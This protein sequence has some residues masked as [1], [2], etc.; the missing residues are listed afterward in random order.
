M[1]VIVAGVMTAMHSRRFCF[2]R[3]LGLEP[4]GGGE[5]GCLVRL[6]R[7][8]AGEHVDE[9]LADIDAKAAAVFHDGV[10]DR[11]GLAGLLTA[12]EQPVLGTNLG[13][14]HGVFQQVVVDL[15]PPVGQEPAEALPVA[16]DIG[17]R[18]AQLAL[19]Q[20]RGPQCE[21]PEDFAEPLENHPGFRRA[22]RGPQRGAGLGLAQA[23]FDLVEQGVLPQ[24]PAHQPGILRG[25]LGELAPGVGVAAGQPDPRPLGRPGAVGAVGVALDEVQDVVDLF[26]GGL[27]GQFGVGAEEFRRAAGITPGTPLVEH[28]A[29]GN[30]AHPEV[31][32]LGL[33]GAGFEISDGGFVKLSVSTSPVF[34]LDFPID[35]LEP[36]GAEHR[37]GAEGLAVEVRAEGDEHFGEPIVGQVQGEAVVND[38][39]DEGRV[40]GAALQ[41]AGRQRGDDGLGDG[42]VDF[43]I[44]A[45][46]L[47]Q[48]AEGAGGEADAFGD[49]LA[50]AAEGGG[51]G[52]HLGRV[53]G[54]DGDGQVGRDAVAARLRGAFRTGGRGEVRGG[55]GAG[56]RPSSPRS[57]S[58]WLGSSCSLDLPKRRRLSRSTAWRSCSLSALSSATFAV[59]EAI[60]SSSSCSRAGVIYYVYS[61]NAGGGRV[62]S[63]ISIFFP[64]FS[65]FF[66]TGCRTPWAAMPEGA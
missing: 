53:D 4:V 40:G 39:G 14:A 57:S 28:A 36:V 24:D 32:L 63:R 26:F 55:G 37:V 66:Q 60:F 31:A 21:A 18:L 7:G 62:C 42:V 50:D 51:I 52:Q 59:S 23:G 6:H 10:K 34:G 3:L 5:R 43:D 12:D 27:V 8:Q 54:Y 25:G 46:H 44:F 16:D 35:D 38:L 65:N 1:G 2:R 56:W 22:H 47:A 29:A 13:R 20:D 9:I 41:Q 33:A 49:F 45:A 30:V 48:D 11:R 17:Q 19:G 58:S 61:S 15:E 64:I